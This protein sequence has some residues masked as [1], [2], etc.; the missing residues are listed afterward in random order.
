MLSH[1]ISERKHNS[2][3]HAKFIGLFVTRLKQQ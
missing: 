3:S 2:L 1:E